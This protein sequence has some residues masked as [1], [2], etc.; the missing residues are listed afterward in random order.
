MYQAESYI[1]VVSGYNWTDAYATLD[2]DVK[3]ILKEAASNIA[4]IYVL[5]Y[6]L[7]GISLAEAQTRIDVLRDQ[8]L[9][10]I[11]LLKDRARTD[12]VIDP[13]KA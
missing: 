13:T 11:E 7:S 1:N 4:A 8:A 9:K 12:F 10:C 3:C 2:N 6:D 5:N